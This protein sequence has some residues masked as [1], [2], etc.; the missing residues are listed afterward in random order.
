MPS[1]RNYLIVVHLTFVYCA[2]IYA[3]NAEDFFRQGSRSFVAQDRPAAIAAFR[4]SLELRPDFAPAW[5]ALGVVFASQGDFDNAEDSFRNA[6]ERQPALADAC[7]YHG[8]TLY[9]LNRFQ[10]AV[11]VLRPVL[12]REKENA[13]AWRLLALSLEALGE[14]TPAGDAFRQSVRFNRGASPNEDPG[15]DYGVYL[16]R[17]GRAEEAIVPLDAAARRHPDSFRAQLEL[18]CVQL[19]LDRLDEAA[20]HLQRAVTLDPRGARAHLLLGKVYQRQGKDREA[21]EQV[22]LGSSR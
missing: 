9:L 16:F 17:Q 7:L 4:K 22:R 8:R 10:P 3:Q 6:C 20:S 5:K 13:E 11:N 14:I 19:A 21:A 18:G 12:Q 15:I 1:A 2:V